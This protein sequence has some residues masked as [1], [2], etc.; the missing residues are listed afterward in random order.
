MRKKLFSLVLVLS[1]AVGMLAGCGNGGTENPD[2][3][4]TTA[5][6]AT[7]A[8][9]EAP[10]PTEAPAGEA[11]PEAKYYFPFEDATGVTLKVNDFT[12][13]TTDTRV[14]DTEKTL[15]FTN[16]VKGQCAWFDGTYGAELAV[17]P[18]DTDT[19]TISFWVNAQRYSTYGAVITMGSDF[20]SEN[21]SAKWLN[22]TR[23]EFDGVTFP[24]FWSR[25][26]AQNIWPWFNYKTETEAGKKEWVHITLV[27]D[28]N[29]WT[30]DG[31]YIDADLYI[32]GVLADKSAQLFAGYPNYMCLTPGIFGADETFH[33]F[34]GINCWDAIFKG[35]IDELYI[36]DQA[37]T[38]G[39]VATLY[40]DGNT[41]EQPV[42]PAGEQEGRDHSDVTTTGYVLGTTDCKTAAGTVYTDTKVVPA[43]GSVELEFTNYT[44]GETF[45]DVFN[46]ILQNVGGAHSTADNAAY[47]EHAVVSSAL[48]NNSALESYLVRNT[49]N[50]FNPKTFG[51][52]TDRAKYVVTVKN[53]GTTA[54]VLMT[55]NCADGITRYLEY[56]GIPVEGEVH[57][58][59]TVAGGFLDYLPDIMIQGKAVGNTDLTS[60]FWTSFSEPVKVEVGE[61]VTTRLI[62]YTL[63]KAAY[64][65]WVTVLQNVPAVHNNVDDPAYKEYAVVRGDNYGWLY[66]LNTNANLAD[67][68]WTMENTWG[69]VSGLTESAADNGIV[70]NEAA[71][72]ADMSEATVDVAVTNHGTYAEVV[73][74]ITTKDGKVFTQKYGNIAVDGDLYYCFVADSSC[75]DIIGT[76]QGTALGAFD[77]SNGFWTAHSNPVHVPAGETV[78]TN[79][80]NHTKGSFAYQNWVVIL[81]NV[82]TGHSSADNPNYSEY[83]VFRADNYAWLYA[84][85]TNA[86]L[87]ELGWTMEN[88]W[89][90]VSGLT[91]S[92][93]DNGIV[94]NE[95]AFC[96][97]MTDAHV[98]V[99][100]TN[101]G[102]TADIVATIT[103]KDGKVFTQKYGNIAVNGDLY[104][105]FT[106]DGSWLDILAE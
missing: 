65:N 75:L 37:L 41:S 95:A 62:N 81:Q 56:V 76:Y 99:A 23:T 59:L 69:F 44:K 24:T 85:N 4:P 36:F 79:L 53:N 49:F 33:F 38:A 17:E 89:G 104:Y 70:A 20:Y 31:I 50:Q 42:N 1:M 25:D 52:N 64:Q 82:A 47:K 28:E 34:L 19:W 40:A 66:A 102:T 60:G 105:C 9:T 58:A 72:C 11:I 77:Y 80:I 14:V 10:K 55:A 22:I 96:A 87:A 93:A 18:L 45:E 39:Q 15:Y 5:P 98:S 13:T 32:D 68:G 86:N 91:E 106:V 16:G 29:K 3:T 84:L 73:A 57:V 6:T 12:G 27:S 63:G 78:T 8:P 83:G 97:D 103:T 48:P 61:T 92:A 54:D 51:D 26:E 100:V 88:N 94:P 43:G 101:N 74:T 30:E 7:T 21:A 46:L 71:F 35:A 67:L 90:F 2:P